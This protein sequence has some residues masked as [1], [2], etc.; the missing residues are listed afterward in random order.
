MSAAELWLVRHGPAGERDPRRW[1]D[2]TLR[3]LT[4]HGRAVLA[5]AARALDGHGVR[6][7]HLLTSPYTRCRETASLLRDLSDRD[8]VP[9]R[10]LGHGGEPSDAIAAAR[11]LDGTVA[12]VGHSPDLE[13]LLGTLLRAPPQAF[14]LRKAGIAVVSLGGERPTLR[15]LLEPRPYLSG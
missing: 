5:E 2:D 8:P 3:P 7:A 15:L 11:N 1:P 13:G 6:W 4:A 12:L 9:L 10:A 14:R